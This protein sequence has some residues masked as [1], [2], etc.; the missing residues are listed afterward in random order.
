MRPRK[1]VSRPSG[2]GSSVFAVEG[3][4]LHRCEV[5]DEADLDAA[6]ARFD[7]LSR[8]VPQLESTAVQAYER[9]QASFAARNWDAVA[10]ILADDGFSRRPPPRGGRGFREGR[11]AVVAEFS[12]FAEIGVKR[13]TFDPI[14]TRGS[15]L[16]LSRSRASGRDR[17]ADAFRTDVLSIAEIDANERIKALIT[18]D[19]DDFDAAFEELEEALSRR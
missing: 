18:F 4:L 13:I 1:R 8:P 6:I 3:D 7:Q 5:F 10:E 14:A 11:H 17:R 12:V 2:A 16:V 19:P 15:R 9:L